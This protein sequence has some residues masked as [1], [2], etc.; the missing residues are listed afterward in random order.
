M[1]A[2]DAQRVWFPEMIEEL[3]TSWS[4]T[5]SWNELADLCARMTDMRKQIREERG[6]QP[7]KTRCPKCGQVSRSDI[8]GVSIRSA[9]FALKNNGVITDDEFKK[10]DKSWTAH[11]KRNGLTAFGRR[12][13]T[14]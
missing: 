9:L 10:L 6:I 11:R 12:T 7:P 8:S 14:C 4:E 2:G 3:K 5:M 1:P 13:E